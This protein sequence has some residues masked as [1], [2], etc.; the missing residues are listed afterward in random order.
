MLNQVLP[1][2][3]VRLCATV[4]IAL[5]AMEVDAQLVINEYSAANKD[6]F[7]TSTEQ[8]MDRGNNISKAKFE[9]WV[10]LYNPTSNSVS[11]QGYTLSDNPTKPN[12]FSI[13]ANVIVPAKSSVVFVC[14][15]KNGYF[16]NQHHTNFKLSQ[17]KGKE[18]LTLSRNGVVIDSVKV[19]AAKKN[20]SRGRVTDGN[21]QW[22]VFEV[23]T[24]GAQNVNGKS[25]Y[26]TSPE[27]NQEAAFFNGATVIA[28]TTLEADAAVYYT[29]DGSDPAI[30][31]TA[32]VYAAPIQVAQTTSLRSCVRPNTGNNSLASPVVTNT[33]FINENHTLPVISICSGDFGALFQF[34]KPQLEIAGSLEFFDKNKT[35]QFKVEGGIKGHGNDSWYYEQK[36]MRFYV[37]DEYGEASKIE[38]PLF[39]TSDRT[40]FDCLI[41]RAAGSDNY[42]G[43]AGSMA[44]THVRDGFAQTLAEKGKL[45]VD[46]R[47]Y[48]AVVIYLNGQYWGV[49]EMRERVDEKFTKEY[50][51]QGKEDVDML[52][53]YGGL[54]VENEATNSS[55]KD[56]WCALYQYVQNNNMADSA[57][58]AYVA[59]E[60]DV[61]SLIDYFTLNTFLVNSDWL[62]WNTAWWR[63]KKGDGVKWRYKLWDQDNI[64]NLGQNFSNLPSMDAATANVC[65]VENLN[66]FKNAGCEQGHVDIFNALMNNSKF[67]QLYINRYADLLNTTFSRNNMLDNLNGM[68]ADMQ[69]EMQRHCARWEPGNAN[70]YQVWLNNVEQLRSQIKARAAKVYAS[71]DT[72]YSVSPV[73]GIVVDVTPVGAGNVMVNSVLPN[74]YPVSLTYFSNVN[75][76]FTASAIGNYKFSHWAVKGSNTQYS[77]ANFDK[78]FTQGDTI[79]A[80]FVEN[81]HKPVVV[82]VDSNLKN[83]HVAVSSDLSNL[84]KTNSLPTV[85]IDAVDDYVFT[86]EI[87]KAAFDEEDNTVNENGY[88]NAP[89]RV[90]SNKIVVPNAFTPNGDGRNDVLEVLGASLSNFEFAVYNANGALVFR[91]N[92]QSEGWDGTFNSSL[93]AVGTYVYFVS[94]MLE[95]GT[96]VFTNSTFTLLR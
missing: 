19:L 17:T 18:T 65:D 80:V 47:K 43:F 24:P 61:L 23:A 54:S 71:M 28:L 15:G 52:S 34:M 85:A 60:L 91:T 37:R 6:A 5:F 57:A 30:S 95:D 25:R 42:V 21:L 75:V 49:Y 88:E 14:S 13:P 82:R 81:Q 7:Q 45:N 87:D 84:G 11:L 89:G 86:A 50:Y 66:Q 69:P 44:S 22:G 1:T 59:S 67:H 41:L 55:A 12:K 70:S 8:V 2:Q 9:D 92:S 46:T 51:G 40:N 56:D 27:V 64:L 10:E 73:S 20:H 72:C 74:A 94:G 90:Y 79:V 96:K 4:A 33:Y 53:Y 58:Y 48:E 16:N 38:Y 3:G 32:K 62:N 93:C 76:N 77:T 68:V 29:T 36:G 31:A 83:V 35:R 26:L 78:S 39:H 63:G